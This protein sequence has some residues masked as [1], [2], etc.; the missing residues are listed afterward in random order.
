ME[1]V[2]SQIPRDTSADTWT[3]PPQG[4]WT[5]EDYA[6]LPDVPG[7]RYEVI[8][9]H[10][11][12]TPAPNIPHQRAVSRLHAA[13]L[14]H[15]HQHELGEVFV[16]PLDV[17]MGDIATPVQ[18]DILFISKERREYL[19]RKNIQGA[20][21]LLVEVL[22]PNREGYD[23]QT[24]FD[25]YRRAGVSEYWIVDPADR[26]IEIYVLR[27]EQVYVGLGVFTLTQEARSE[28]LA[29]FR[30]AVDYICPPP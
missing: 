2:A 6:R 3:P 27:D 24:K 30:T 14:H 12:M 20:P 16:S 9:G 5:Y 11:S 13:M 17:L 8:E 28:V 18:P 4:Q 23:R 1:Y 29:G 26:R 25:A 19:T 7:Y 22:S 21:D 15:A 10:I